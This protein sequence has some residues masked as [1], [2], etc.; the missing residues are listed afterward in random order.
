SAV[1]V[2][3][4]TRRGVRRCAVSAGREL[5]GGGHVD[6]RRGQ[7]TRVEQHLLANR[8][9]G[10]RVVP[11]DARVELGDRDVG[12]TDTDL[13]GGLHRA[14]GGDTGARFGREG[15]V[16]V[17]E[18]HAGD[19]AQLV[20]LGVVFRDRYGFGRFAR[21]RGCRGE[22]PRETADVGGSVS[23]RELPA[24]GLARRAV[25]YVGEVRQ[26]RRQ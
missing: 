21:E 14:V 11:L 24:R 18:A 26:R 19:A 8:A 1:R 9:H 3:V 22:L 7:L 13:E 23:R 17:D 12:A 4:A 20:Q 10:S 2:E 6:F 15:G 16:R 25:P 5:E